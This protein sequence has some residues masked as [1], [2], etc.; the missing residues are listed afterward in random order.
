MNAGKLPDHISYSQL[1]VYL[2]C[3]LKYRFHYID[4]LDPAFTAASLAFGQAVHQAVASFF[5]GALEGEYLSADNMIDVYREAWRGCEGPPIQYSNG[6]T[7]KKLLKK[8]A[9][10]LTLWHS[11]QDPT[12]EVYG[13]EEQFSVDLCQKADSPG[14]GLPALVGYVDHIL[15]MP[16]GNITLIDLKTAARKPSQ[17]QVDQTLQLTAYSLGAEALGFNPDELS[18]RMDYLLKTATP[19]LVTYETSRSEEDRRKFVK[20]L[21]RVWKGIEASIF[22]PKPDWYCRSSCGYQSQC[23]EW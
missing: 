11:R 20:M 1:A 16:D 14:N 22:Y 6:D 13:V 18:L 17:L 7:E 8:A 3:P 12:I 19:D 10:I 2:Q 23:S 9:D 4:G 21:T 15:K 5:Q